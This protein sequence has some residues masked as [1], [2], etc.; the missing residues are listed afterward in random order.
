LLFAA[1]VAAVADGAVGQLPVVKLQ[2]FPL[3]GEVRIAYDEL[4]DFTFVAYEL[5]SPIGA[6]NG[7]NGI[8]KSIADTYDASG[9]GFIDPN[10][11]WTELTPS[12]G[13]NA[14]SLSEGSVPN[15]GGVFP[16]NRSLSLGNIWDPSLTPPPA[17]PD[18]TLTIYFSDT[19]SKKYDGVQSVDGDYF[20]NG[21]VDSLDY[22]FWKLAFGSTSANYADG[23][24]DGVVN[25][26]DYTIWRNNLGQGVPGSG[27]GESGEAGVALSVTAVPEP[28]GMIL[29]LLTMVGGF[30]CRFRLRRLSC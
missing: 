27:S 14:T 30:V 24:L 13:A 17:A 3:T 10:N 26:A 19:E 29:G 5:K 15:P 4:T 8:W 18:V 28:A 22:T 2:L 16:A 6:L 23:N 25:A 21:N 9:N 12:A 20:R 1:V 11:E 7:T